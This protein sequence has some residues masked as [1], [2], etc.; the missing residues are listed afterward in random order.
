MT[1]EQNQAFEIRGPQRQDFLICT[2]KKSEAIIP[3]IKKAKGD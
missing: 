2:Q 3:R 1:E